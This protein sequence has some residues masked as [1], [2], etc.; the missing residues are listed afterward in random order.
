MIKHSFDTQNPLGQITL[1]AEKHNRVKRNTDA[2]QTFLV[3]GE[4]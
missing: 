4:K 3:R 2:G 1:S